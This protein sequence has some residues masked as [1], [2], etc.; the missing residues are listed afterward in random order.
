MEKQAE[1][2]IFITS[3]I[4][5]SKFD[6]E[7]ELVANSCD[8]IQQKSGRGITVARLAALAN[9]SKYHFSRIFKRHTNMT[10]LEY[11]DK[12]RLNY[13]MALEQSGCR[14][15]QIAEKLGFS[16]DAVYRR[17]RRKYLNQHAAKIKQT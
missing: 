11:I 9:Y 6:R 15:K 5:K 2:H 12:V 7:R 16:S 3:S 4:N 8:Y 13:A 10:I 17:W 1:G 14:S